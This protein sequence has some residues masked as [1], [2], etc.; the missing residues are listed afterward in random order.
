MMPLKL[1]LRMLLVAFV[2]ACGACDT[3]PDLDCGQ[4]DCTDCGELATALG[5]GQS[6]SDHCTIC[7]GAEP[8]ANDNACLNHPVVGGRHVIQGCSTDAD[9]KGLATLC[10]R[11]LGFPHFTCVFGDDK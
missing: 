8:G 7:N 1:R 3:S 5:W 2:L 10:A 11:F 6:E 9:C 4:V